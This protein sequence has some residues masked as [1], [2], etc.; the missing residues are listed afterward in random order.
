MQKTT[1]IIFLWS[2]VAGI[3]ASRFLLVLFTAIPNSAAQIILACLLLLLGVLLFF[4]PKFF[5][6]MANKQIVC[7]VIGAALAWASVMWMGWQTVQTFADTAKPTASESY[8]LERPT[9]SN[10]S[11]WPDTA[12]VID[13]HNLFW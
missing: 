6:Q 3:A 8:T 2:L 12:Q 4:A 9:S 10:E 5:K 1:T 13:L 7:M 11:A